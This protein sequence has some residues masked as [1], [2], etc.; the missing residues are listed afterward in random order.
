[1]AHVQQCTCMSMVFWY[2][3][4][5]VYTAQYVFVHFVF[6][7]FIVNS[8]C[9]NRCP[10]V[11]SFMLRMFAA[12]KEEMRVAWIYAPIYIDSPPYMTQTNRSYLQTP[13]SYTSIGSF[14]FD[15]YRTAESFATASVGS[16]LPQK[17]A[18]AGWMVAGTTDPHNILGLG[19]VSGPSLVAVA[20]AVFVAG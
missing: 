5:K 3:M 20:A 15:C 13:K 16:T 7:C 6:L 9:D 14:P 18:L 17:A 12:R 19:P 2:F 10:I 11:L 8:G 1:M 4:Y